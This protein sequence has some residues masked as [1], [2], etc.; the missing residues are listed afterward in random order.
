MMIDRRFFLFAGAALASG[1]LAQPAQNGQANARPRIDVDFGPELA[2]LGAG[3]RLGVA[4]IEVATGRSLGH[5]EGSRYAMCSTFKL[6]LAAM[7]LAEVEAGRM[8]LDRQIPF[9]RADI[10]NNSPVV[11][12]NLAAG[13]L[14]VERLCA[15]AV[16]VSDNAAANLLLA[17]VGGPAGLTRFIRSAGDSVTRCDRTE[18]ELNSNVPGDP[19]D[20]STPQAM[21]GL[22]SS[23]LC[24]NRLNPASRSRLIG[25]MEGTTTGLDRLRA[26]LPAGW[27]VGDKTGTGGGANNDLVIAWPPG[28]GPI[29][30]ACFTDG[31]EQSPAV[32][33]PV[34]AAVASKIAAAFA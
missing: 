21:A 32:R 28:R 6:P 10:L 17:M 12:A 25:W 27:R 16:Q 31:H 2:M 22:L 7:I 14:P 11:E 24:G 1:C 26:G 3:G 15:A 23:L 20:T 8:S 4:A 33:S 18:P 29:V 9:S 5:D 30:I 13:R 34:H 19:R